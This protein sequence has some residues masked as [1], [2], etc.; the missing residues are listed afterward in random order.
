MQQSYKHHRPYFSETSACHLI[1]L[2]TFSLIFPNFYI[3][4]RFAIICKPIFYTGPPIC[5]DVY[6]ILLGNIITSQRS[7]LQNRTWSCITF[8]LRQRIN[9]LN[10]STS[11]PQLLSRDLSLYIPCRTCGSV[12]FQ[13]LP[14]PACV[15]LLLLKLFCNPQ[16]ILFVYKKTS[17]ENSSLGIARNGVQVVVHTV[18]LYRPPLFCFKDSCDNTSSVQKGRSLYLYIINSCVRYAY[19]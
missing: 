16:N 6:D 19:C 10:I 18:L 5:Q 15:S 1:C 9:L 12:P 7:M 4:F 2:Q 17:L 3:L 11:N 8:P 14:G 13:S